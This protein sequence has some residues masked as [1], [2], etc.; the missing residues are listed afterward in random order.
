VL[1]AV[2]DAEIARFLGKGPTKEEALR[3]LAAR[4]EL[5]DRMR[6]HRWIA[7]ETARRAGATWTEVAAAAGMAPQDARCLYETTLSRQKSFGLAEPQRH[8]PGRPEL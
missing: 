2:V 7:M 8:D 3:A 4:R 6:R 1:A 5:E